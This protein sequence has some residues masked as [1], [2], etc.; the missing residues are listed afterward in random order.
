MDAMLN[1]LRDDAPLEGAKLRAN[2]LTEASLEA[3]PGAC[4]QH[5]T[6]HHAAMASDHP[7]ERCA[8][9][10]DLLHAHTYEAPAVASVAHADTHVG[11]TL[12]SS[13]LDRSLASADDFCEGNESQ[14]RKLVKQ[15]QTTSHELSSIG[16]LICCGCRQAARGQLAQLPLHDRTQSFRESVGWMI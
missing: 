7:V 12:A 9:M 14:T 10:H 1:G 16:V 15:P 3:A 5:L 11:A 4:R 13:R 8:G 2:V 6:W